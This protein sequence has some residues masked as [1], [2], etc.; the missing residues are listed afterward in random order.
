[1]LNLTPNIWL[2]LLLP[3]RVWIDAALYLRDT[4]LMLQDHRHY[5]N[6]SAD[7]HGD[8]RNK[9]TAKMED[10]FHGTTPEC[11]STADR[12]HSHEILVELTG[13]EPVASWLQTRR[14]PS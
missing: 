12:I 5:S 2:V 8:D 11:K 13:I 3:G 9:E 6:D 14:S 1:L 10:R 7:D 4:F